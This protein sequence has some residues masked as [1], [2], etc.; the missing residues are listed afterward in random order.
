LGIKKERKSHNV[1]VVMEQDWEKRDRER[2]RERETKNIQ[3]V[4]RRSD[5]GKEAE[6]K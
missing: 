3:L 2:E 5:D 6:L 1:Y 4:N